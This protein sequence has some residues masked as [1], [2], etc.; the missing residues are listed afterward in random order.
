MWKQ[1]KLL[2]R[3]LTAPVVFDRNIVVGDVEGYLHV[4]SP[5]DG[6]LIGRV[7]TDGSAIRSIVPTL[8]G[9]LVQTEKGSVV[10]VRF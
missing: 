9:L 1:D 2:Y 6:T 10:M 7:A 8:S 3:R 5:V 4:L